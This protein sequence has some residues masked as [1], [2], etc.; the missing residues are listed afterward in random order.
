IFCCQYLFF[1]LT[2]FF[3]SG[4][5]PRPAKDVFIPN[6]STTVKPFFV[7]VEKTSGGCVQPPAM[8][9]TEG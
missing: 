7:R 3:F 1:A 2:T 9:R 8:V 5:L 6:P 4:I